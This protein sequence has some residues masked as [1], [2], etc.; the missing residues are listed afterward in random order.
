MQAASAA[1]L[2]QSDEAIANSAARTAKAERTKNGIN[3]GSPICSKEKIL[4]AAL[5]PYTQFL[6]TGT[7]SGALLCFDF[8]QGAVAYRIQAHGAPVSALAYCRVAEQALVFTGSWDRAMHIYVVSKSG[9]TQISAVADAAGDFIKAICVSTKHRVAITGGSDR[10]VRVW[11]LSLL[12]DWISQGSVG[13]APVPTLAA[14]ARHHTRP[15]TSIAIIPDAPGVIRSDAGI[16]DLDIFSADSMGRVVHSRMENGRVEA[17]R[18]LDGNETAVNDIVVSWRAVDP[19]D[20][21]VDQG[22]DEEWVPDVWTASVD[23]HARRFPLSPS[24]REGAVRGRSSAAGAPVG[25]E[26]PI[27][28]DR[29]LEHPHSVGAV[30]VVGDSVVTT[31]DG[32]LWMWCGA[33]AACTEGHSHEAGYLGVWMHEGEPRIVSAGLDGSVRRWPLHVLHGAKPA[34]VENVGQDAGPALTAEEEAELA[35][36]M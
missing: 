19:S 31:C 26:R 9:A 12:F 5:C 17:V 4:A 30:A 22:I 16:S 1:Q 3:Y 35:E 15:I 36:L 24:A 29:A 32:D 8:D 25:T 21:L 23:K 2:F 11:D 20:A 18:E 6:L 14:V 28:A 7:S 34:V 13:E 10:T 33:K 27:L